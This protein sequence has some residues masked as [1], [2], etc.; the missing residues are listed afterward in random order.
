MNRQ[1]LPP[2]EHPVCDVYITDNSI[3][4][5]CLWSE[6]SKELLGGSVLEL[7]VLVAFAVQSDSCRI[8]YHTH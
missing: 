2:I 4:N 1:S 6:R 3:I 7:R 5:P 8:H